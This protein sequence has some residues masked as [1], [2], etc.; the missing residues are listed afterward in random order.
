MG[1]LL[2][3]TVHAA[4]GTI[5]CWSLRVRQQPERFGERS[6]SGESQEEEGRFGSGGSASEGASAKQVPRQ[7]SRKRRH[8]AASLATRSHQASL[9]PPNMFFALTCFPSSFT[10]KALFASRRQPPFAIPA[11]MQDALFLAATMNRN[12]TDNK[13]VTIPIG[14]TLEVPDH[15]TWESY[16]GKTCACTASTTPAPTPCQV[17]FNSATA[18]DISTSMISIWCEAIPESG[19]YCPTDD[20]SAAQRLVGGGQA[21]LAAVLEALNC[22]SIK[23]CIVTQSIVS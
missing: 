11:S 8:N 1:N 21:A 18:L 19:C 22:D 14:G 4:N 13:A 12:C 5:P 6:A 10:I 3:S 20:K 7:F 16:A 9:N 17:K 23:I 15:V 2:H